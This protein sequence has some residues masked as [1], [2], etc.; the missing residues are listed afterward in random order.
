MGTCITSA[1]WHSYG[2]ALTYSYLLALLAPLHI[3]F[4][5]LCPQPS[6]YL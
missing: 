4:Y 2:M 1:F 5:V 6:K 3:P